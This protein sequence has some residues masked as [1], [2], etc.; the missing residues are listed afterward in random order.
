M[1][2]SKHRYRYSYIVNLVLSQA[3]HKQL[4]NKW[5]FRRTIRK[6]YCYKLYL[7]SC[8]YFGETQSLL[9]NNCKA[10][11]A[12]SC[13]LTKLTFIRAPPIVSSKSASSLK[14][15]VLL[16]AALPAEILPI[17]TARFLRTKVLPVPL[18]LY[19][20]A[21]PVPGEAC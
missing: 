19:N 1:N 20:A 9:I 7:L 11:L 21:E 14:A 8:H 6:I 2:Q 18:A 16:D 5:C 15:S 17:M 4:H 3:L 13:T 10:P 12:R